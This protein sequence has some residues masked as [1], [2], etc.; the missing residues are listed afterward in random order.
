MIP[1]DVSSPPGSDLP[2]ENRY[3][4]TSAGGL[5]DKRPINRWEAKTAGPVQ[6]KGLEDYLVSTRWGME[7]KVPFLTTTWACHLREGRSEPSRWRKL[8][9]RGGLERA[10]R[11]GGVSELA[12]HSQVRC[13]YH[14]SSC[15]PAVFTEI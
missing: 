6:Y 14:G 12:S 11:M 1:A 7:W 8:P 9:G 13:A 4:V 10:R 2:T 3:Q 15:N 5:I